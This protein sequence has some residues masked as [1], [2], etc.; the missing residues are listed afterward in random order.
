M[1]KWFRGVE[2]TDITFV[3]LFSF[4]EWI[5]L[6]YPAK[7]ISGLDRTKDEGISLLFETE[8]EM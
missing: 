6:E 3:V 1:R 2:S 7:D 4:S 5:V 8:V